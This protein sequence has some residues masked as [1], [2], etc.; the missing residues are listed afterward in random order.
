MTN[1]SATNKEWWEKMVRDECGF[2][3]PW[4]NI[5]TEA[6]NKYLD[7]HLQNPPEPINKV[8]PK[9][10]FRNV[11]GKDV[12]CLASG[13][14]QQ[15]AVFAQL[16]ANV[17]VNDI[18][19]GQLEGDKQAAKYYGYD[20]ITIQGDM[21]NLSSLDDNSFDIV[22]QPPSMGYIP[23][24]RKVYAEVS[25]LIRSGGL[26]SADAQNPLTQFV[27][28]S[29]WDGKGYRIDVPYAIKEKQRS[30]NANVIEYRHT[31]EDTFNGLIEN[32]FVIKK[33]EEMHQG[34]YGSGESEPGSWLHS[35]LYI[36]GLFAIL[37]RKK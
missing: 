18:A 21:S 36:P 22:Y 5:D 8:F 9:S 30:E 28:E 2:T 16:G 13:G 17:T 27:D 32:D 33:V 14:G 15:S 26:Y 11:K 6:L 24:V 31:L 29:T 20:V 37:A 1:Y 23:D 34:I 4:L 10:I 19:D 25:R 7:G 3:K 35:L 12:L